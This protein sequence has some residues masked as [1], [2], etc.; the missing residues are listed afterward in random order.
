M[1]YEHGACLK[2]G[3]QLLNRHEYVQYSYIY[4]DN[5]NFI[6][7]CFSKYEYVNRY[8]ML[9]YFF[10]INYKTVSRVCM[11][12]KKINIV[13]IFDTVMLVSTMSLDKII[14]LK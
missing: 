3:S 5:F 8:V 12:K 1:C 13:L 9:M 7:Y 10:T 4:R 14:V 11:I 6:S 2:F